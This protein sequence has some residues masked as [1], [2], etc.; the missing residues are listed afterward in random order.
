MII[1]CECGT[2]INQATADR[3]ELCGICYC[4]KCLPITEKACKSCRGVT[5]HKPIELKTFK[6]PEKDKMFLDLGSGLVIALFL[7]LLASL[8]YCFYQNI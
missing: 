7:W 4:Q 1:E 8:I 6:A 3:C 5:P 2:M